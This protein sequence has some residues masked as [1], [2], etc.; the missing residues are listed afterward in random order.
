MKR[1]LTRYILYTKICNTREISTL[2]C[3]NISDAMQNGEWDKNNVFNHE[4]SIILWRMKREKY[5]LNPTYGTYVTIIV[6]DTHMK[7]NTHE[8]TQTFIRC[9]WNWSGLSTKKKELKEVFASE[10]KLAICIPFLWQMFIFKQI[11]MKYV[12]Q[13]MFR[14][15][16]HTC[17]CEWHIFICNRESW[18]SCQKQQICPESFINSLSPK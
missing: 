1:H 18:H 13:S 5:S 4:P 17:C 15:S 16:V 9:I 2:K 11:A 14:Y 6:D 10:P 12:C 7:T 3:Q 8:Q